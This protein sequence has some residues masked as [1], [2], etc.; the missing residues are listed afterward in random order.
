[1]Q[2]AGGGSSASHSVLGMFTSTF[3]EAGIRGLYR[4]VSA[5]L[6][7]TTPIIALSFWGYDLGQRTVRYMLDKNISPTSDLSLTD[8]SLILG[9][10]EIA[11]SQIVVVTDS[12]SEWFRKAVQDEV[13]QSGDRG[14]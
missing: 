11:V 12:L 1:M 3:R 4:G 10:T 14:A 9:G 7:A 13:E 6:L 8:D 2:T 5:P